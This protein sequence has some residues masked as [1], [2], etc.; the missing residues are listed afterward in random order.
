MTDVTLQHDIDELRQHFDAMYVGAIP[1]LLNETG[2]FLAF[3][4]TPDW[5]RSTCGISR[6]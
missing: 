4:A 2:A 1:Q 3:L 5:D 6:T